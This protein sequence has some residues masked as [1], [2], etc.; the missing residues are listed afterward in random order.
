MK[1][2]DTKFLSP[3]ILL[4]IMKIYT[5]LLFV[6]MAKLFA[7][8]ANGQNVTIN[9]KNAEL[10][11]VF[12]EIE[13]LTE[14]NF[15]Y[16]NSLIDV[17]KKVTLNANNQELNTVLVDLFKETDIDYRFL[18][19]QIVLFPKNDKE[20]IKI[21]E[22]LINN[23]N[24]DKE[25]ETLIKDVLQN[26]VKGTVTDAAGVPLAGVNIIIQ[27]T[28]TGT[29]SDFD[30]N[31][32][33]AANE[34]DVLEFSYI[35]FKTETVTVGDSNTVNLTMTEDA[36]ELD[37]VVVTALGIKRQEKTLTYA[38]QTVQGDDLTKS[39]DI[40]FMNALSGKTAGVEIRQSSSGPGGSTKVQIRGHKSASGDSSPLFVIDGVPIVNNRGSQPSGWDGVDGGDGLS[41]LNPDDIES[42]SVLKGA[43][44]AILYGS[45]GANG[46]IIITTKSGKAGVT[47][48]Q[49]NSS[50]S[51]RSI[52]DSAAPDLQY[53]YGSEN[54]SR[55]SWSTTQGDYASNFVDDWFETGVDFI[56]SVS[57]SGGN[58]KTQA[59]FSYSNTSSAGITPAN[60]Y[61]KNNFTFKQSTKFFD[62]KVKVTSNIILSNENTSNRNRAGYYNNPLTGLYWFPRE[63]NFE[64]FK[65][66]YYMLDES[67]QVEVMNWFVSDH[68]QSN[69]YWLL[70]R[71]TQQDRFKRVIANLAAEWQITDKLRFQTRFNID[72]A[73]KEY[74]ERR[75]AGGNTTTVAR[76][77]RWIYSDFNDT[78]TYMD[79]IF[80]YTNEF[81]EDFSVN[82]LLG[83]TYQRTEYGDGVSVN[84][85]MQDNGLLYANEFN[86]NN[87]GPNVLI[88]STL[89]QRVEKNSIFGNIEIGYKDMLFLDLAGRND[90]ASTLALTGNDS[91][92]YNSAG[93]SAI[94]TEMFEMP[95]WIS[96]LKARVSLAELANEV[97]FNIVN[98]ANS[99]IGG[100][101]VNQYQGRP[102]FDARPE[103]IS[104]WEVGIDWRMFQGRLGID[105]TYYDITSKDQFLQFP[106]DSALYT[107]EYINAG[108]ITNKG[109][110]IILSGKPI[111]NNDFNWSTSFNYTAN[112]N[113]IVELSPNALGSNL[114]GTEGFAAPLLEGG[115]FG[116]LWARGFLRD[117]QG[118]IELDTDGSPIRDEE[119]RLF[120]NAEPDFAL[121]WN[122]TISY[123]SWSLNMQ[124]NGKFGG[125]V[126]SQ[127]ESMLDGFGV[128]ERSAAARDRGFE[129]INAVQN[130]TPVTQ[131]DPELYYSEG[132]GTGGRNGIQEPYIYDR[133]NVRL[134]QLSVSYNFNVDK[135]DWLKSASLSFIGNNLF[136]FYKDA[137]F[138]PEI[139]NSTGRSQPGIENINLPATRTTGLNLSL[140]F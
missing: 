75:Q 109:V 35:G 21:I 129:T 62:D 12:T 52:I 10:K 113:K 97:P 107:F 77:G 66:N 89:N 135:Y 46:V 59:Y 61:L 78:K 118:R 103:I 25:I 101:S 8:D 140:T 92:F 9:V 102:F 71:E 87:T 68:H 64:D 119:Q 130:G 6:S 69:P 93:L 49:V 20:V 53:R 18:K 120:G 96:F 17:S 30:G 72:F 106:I 95:D 15:F 47:T 88:A 86:F 137:P 5:L 2:N 48:V 121:G 60:N 7:V 105:F 108:E 42:M 26:E 37:E 126:G 98:P 104:T 43:N 14:F 84:S 57:I 74:D 65:T 34:G 24:L 82:A 138:D 27:G 22:D 32:S 79:G 51:V 19:D 127:S 11:T 44:A 29:Q 83:A 100:G 76:N 23:E 91:Y 80:S 123:K 40:N 36:S 54:S 55:Y 99:I 4:R 94:F 38:Q 90:W 39:K 125:V 50:L 16:N 132:P 13:T 112:N 110:E 122:N 70:N 56:N 33:I 117:D 28:S 31:Y 3:K 136:F 63:R 133:T 45:E 124:I 58:D 131:I 139:T 41:A 81:G 128:S 1:K 73:N 134:G 114:G 115:S 85:G 111:V 67:R 116:D